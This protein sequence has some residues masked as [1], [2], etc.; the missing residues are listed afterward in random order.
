MVSGQ[1]T[2]C[3]LKIDACSRVLDTRKRSQDWEERAV[4]EG[5]RFTNG[6]DMEVMSYVWTV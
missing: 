1:I 6:I 5:E 4:L 2:A 3:L